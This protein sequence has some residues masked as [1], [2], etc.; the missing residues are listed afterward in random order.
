MLLPVG[1]L[2]VLQDFIKFCR[3]ILKDRPRHIFHH[4]SLHFA[5]FTAYVKHV[6]FPRHCTC[7]QSFGQRRLRRDICILPFPTQQRHQ[8]HVGAAPLLRHLRPLRRARHGRL[9]R[10][11]Q[12]RGGD[13]VAQPPQRGPPLEPT[14]L[15]RLRGVWTH[16][17]R[18]R[19]QRDILKKTRHPTRPSARWQ[20]L[21]TDRA[22][23]QPL[24]VSFSRSE[25]RQNSEEGRSPL[26]Q[27]LQR[28]TT[29]S[30]PTVQR[31][32]IIALAKVRDGPPPKTVAKCPD[33][34]F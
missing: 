8:G 11:V 31:N 21:V 19:P 1:I 25:A 34:F 33:Y 14:L 4:S 24:H 17:R 27:V 3:H 10:P 23:L 15:Q 12:H 7:S 6:Q 30:T 26:D 2:V 32:L 18:V 22:K 9:S 13:V 5:G 29:R 20:G 16:E 28:R